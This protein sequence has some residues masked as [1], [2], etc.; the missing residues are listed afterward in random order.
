MIPYFEI[1]EV[2]T[3]LKVN[4]QHHQAILRH[5]GL[6]RT[7]NQN[8]EVELT[9]PE[10]KPS[11]FPLRVGQKI[12]FNPLDNRGK[13]TSFGG[14]TEG[15]VGKSKLSRHLVG[16]IPTYISGIFAIKVKKKKA[17]NIVQ[18]LHRNGFVCDQKINTKTTI[19]G[20]FISG[21]F[22]NI[23][24]QVKLHSLDPQFDVDQDVWSKYSEWSYYVMPIDFTDHDPS[25]FFL[26]FTFNETTREIP[27]L[28][29]PDI[30]FSNAQF[31]FQVS[32]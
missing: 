7:Q 30:F 27:L 25:R 5:L 17:I 20:D 6:R 9:T 16:K 31:L 22:R 1:S 14:E 21:D 8:N 13:F 12:T 24:V 19:S 28:H 18:V 4:L 32:P 2:R 3:N 10:N 23:I 11:F 26:N 29:D 15:H